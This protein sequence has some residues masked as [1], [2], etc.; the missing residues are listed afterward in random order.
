MLK[1]KNE[2]Q[3]IIMTRITN[4]CELKMMSFAIQTK[5][6]EKFRIEIGKN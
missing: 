4:I 6:R 5:I 1:K 2:I 3:T